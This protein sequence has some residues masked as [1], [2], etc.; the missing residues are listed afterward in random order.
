MLLHGF[1]ST[2]ELT[3][4]KLYFISSEKTPPLAMPI[5]PSAVHFYVCVFRQM[6]FCP[7]IELFANRQIVLIDSFFWYVRVSHSHLVFWVN[8]DVDASILWNRVTENWTFIRARRW[9][10]VGFRWRRARCG[11]MV[12]IDLTT[13]LFPSAVQDEFSAHSD[14]TVNSETNF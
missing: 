4:V 7:S 5:N 8:V 10:H 12:A 11:C 2:N 9:P 3:I 6:V 1:R 13:C 14:G